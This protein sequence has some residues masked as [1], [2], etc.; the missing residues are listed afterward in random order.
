M[1]L[2][3]KG[4]HLERGGM[5]KGLEIWLFQGE[6]LMK[7]TEIFMGQ[8]WSPGPSFYHRESLAESFGTMCK[9]ASSNLPGQRLVGP[10][11]GQKSMTGRD[12]VTVEH[13]NK[14]HLRQLENLALT[15]ASSEAST[16]DYYICYCSYVCFCC[17]VSY[18]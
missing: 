7:L 8:S 2:Y 4:G 15:P 1:P 14:T 5:L 17:Y 12:L 11:W 6:I 18:C 3:S 9:Q 16:L 10:V 13:V